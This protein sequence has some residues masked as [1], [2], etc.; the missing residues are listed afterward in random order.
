MVG[1]DGVVVVVVVG[2]RTMFERCLDEH[3]LPPRL[4]QAQALSQPR[5]SSLGLP[6][7]ID[8]AVWPEVASSVPASLLLGRAATGGLPEFSLL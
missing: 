8:S 2:S 4:L 3:R 1:D 7:A 6:L 5:P